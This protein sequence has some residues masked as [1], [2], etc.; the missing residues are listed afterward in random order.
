MPKRREEMEP[1]PHGTPQ[2]YRWDIADGGTACNECRAAWSKHKREQQAVREGRDPGKTVSRQP[3]EHG[4][5]VRV[6]E[7]HPGWHPGL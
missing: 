2:R 1:P 6:R 7:A 3:A 5:A 4:D